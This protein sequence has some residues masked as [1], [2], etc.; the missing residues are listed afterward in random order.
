M[1]DFHKPVRRPSDVLENLSGNGNPADDSE[2]AHDSAAALLGRVQGASNQSLVDKVIAYADDHG[3]DD[4]AELWADAPPTTLPGAMWRIYL[5]RHIVVTDPAGVAYQFRRG[6]E[7]EGGPNRAIAGSSYAPTPQEVADLATTILR[8]LF[9]GDFAVALE[10]GSAF[11]RVMW[12]GL[13]D[14]ASGDQA[15]SVDHRKQAAGFE[16][17]ADH[18]HAA[19]K[20]WR[21]GQLR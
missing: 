7:V 11:A 12:A 14:L 2:L 20:L 15:R 6:L 13:D 18:L 16:M 4:V 17:M 19:A 1:R 8:G 10:R 21:D 9:T 5:L 3:I